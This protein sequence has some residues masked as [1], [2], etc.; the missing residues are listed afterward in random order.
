M[1]LYPNPKLSVVIPTY[2]RAD[3]LDFSLAAH[4]PLFRKCGI[5]IFIF[6]NASTDSTTEVVNKWSLEYPLISYLRHDENVGADLNFELALKAPDT[7][8]VWLLGDSYLLPEIGIDYILNIDKCI[9]NYDLV[10]MN[11]MGALALP[12]KNYIDYN[13][14]LVD[15]GG[16][17]SCMSCLVYS[18]KLLSEAEFFRYRETNFIQT[19][20]VFEYIAK[21]NF[22]VGWVQH[23]SIGNLT[24]A[25][26]KKTN[27]SSTPEWARIGVEGWL[28]FLFSLPASYKLSSKFAG[29]KLFGEVSGLLHYKTFFLRRADGNLTLSLIYR[30]GRELIICAGFLKVL[31]AICICMIPVPV[32]KVLYSIRNYLK[33]RM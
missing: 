31:F 8:Y 9:T 24:L 26:T 12:S 22:S 30:Y 10:V 15:L 1:K 18:R 7:D 6:D 19:G 11:L 2:N 20:V 27:W 5:Q 14:L 17:M 33:A 25:H 4:V 32:F 23:I 13:D 29:A 16:L 3:F 21:Q 28:K